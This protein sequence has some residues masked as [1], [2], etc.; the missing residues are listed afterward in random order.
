MTI[1]QAVL[2]VLLLAAAT[3]RAWERQVVR[4]RLLHG[5]YNTRKMGALGIVPTKRG[6][7]F[8]DLHPS[9]QAR[10]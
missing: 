2:L 8:T 4:F 10:W 9:P 3:C 1:A 5:K 6:Q 7:V